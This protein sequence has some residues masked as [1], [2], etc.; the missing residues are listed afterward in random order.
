MLTGASSAL[1]LITF[2]LVPRTLEFIFSLIF[3]ICCQ[4]VFV[5]SQ[6][7]TIKGVSLSVIILI[8]LGVLVLLLVMRGGTGFIGLRITV[9]LVTWLG[10][11]IIVEPIVGLLSYYLIRCKRPEDMQAHDDEE[12][13]TEEK[14]L[15]S[16]SSESTNSSSPS[17]GLFGHTGMAAESSPIEPSSATDLDDSLPAHDEGDI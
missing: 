7:K 15:L 2:F 3:G 12:A 9:W 8:A 4:S 13:A 5:K 1:I 11:M 17:S 16:K 10:S 14:P 6:G